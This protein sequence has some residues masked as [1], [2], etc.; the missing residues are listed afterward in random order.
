M[1]GRNLLLLLFFVSISAWSQN[2]F[3]VMEYN[4]ENAFDTIHDEG[5]N[6]YEYCADGE[7]KWSRWKLFQKL[8]NIGKVIA[9]ADENR[10]VDLVALCEV[11][12]DTV[13]T[14]LTQ[15]TKLVNMGYKYIMTNSEDERGVDVALLYSPFTFH[16]IETQ[17]IRPHLP[18]HPTRD[19]LRVAGIIANGD[20]VDAY[21]VHLPSKLGGAAAMKRSIQVTHLLKE[22]IDSIISVR[23]HP[24]I[25]AMGDFNAEPKS[26]Q[27]KLLTRK[28]PLT[29]QSKKLSPGTY[30]YQ[31]NWS[32]IDHIITHTTSLHPSVSHTITLPFLVETDETNGGIKPHRT[33]LGP[34]Y[35]GG[36]SDHLP[37]VTKFTIQK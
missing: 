26:S 14:Y 19:I 7:R 18:K 23:H 12:N 15:R 20:T 8:R 1:F 16:P 36:T 10:P 33:F 3:T 24:N 35:K 31:G 27:L 34:V 5:K 22:N 13:L 6:D 25:I 28:L 9:A 37:I 4:C 32:V 29:D 21:V 17:H 2:A 30:K 11:E